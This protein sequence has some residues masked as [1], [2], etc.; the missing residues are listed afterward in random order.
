MKIHKDCKLELAASKDAS[1]HA[2]AEPFLDIKDGKGQLIATDGRIMAI[3]PVEIDPDDT[4]GYL[5]SDVLKM[6]RKLAKRS[7]TCTVNLN[8]VARLSADTQMPRE[9]GAKDSDGR[10]PNYPNWRQVMPDVDR[11]IKFSISI[12]ANRLWLLAQAMGTQAV[13]LQFKDAES[14]IAVLPTNAPYLNRC[15]NLDARGV[16]IP[17]QPR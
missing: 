1:R 7:D 15:S 6:A 10:I 11:E 3:V 5:S 14:I 9:G 8:S 2:I 17:T 13:T 16:I 12:D 4:Q